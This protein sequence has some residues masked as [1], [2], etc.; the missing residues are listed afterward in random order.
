MTGVNAAVLPGDAR[1]RWEEL[2]AAMTAKNGPDGSISASLSQMEESEA[3]E[4]AEKIAFV[5]SM[6]SHHLEG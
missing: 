5:D 4:I 6:V 1:T 3:V 2:W